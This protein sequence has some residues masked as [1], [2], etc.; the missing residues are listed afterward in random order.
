MSDNMSVQSPMV[1]PDSVAK[2]NPQQ[3]NEAHTKEVGKETATEKINKIQQAEKEA[4][5]EPLEVSDESLSAAVD[6]LNSYVKSAS[7]DLLFS[8]DNDS[9]QTVVRVTDAETEQLIRQIPNEEALKIAK[10]LDGQLQLNS[11]NEATPIGLLLI[12]LTA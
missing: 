2:P 3:A 5:K 11:S 1:L 4:S 7:R 10:Q 8:V 12:Q 6:Q 9:G